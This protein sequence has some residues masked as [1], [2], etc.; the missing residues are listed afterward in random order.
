VQLEKSMERKTMQNNKDGIIHDFKKI[1]TK[2]GYRGGIQR[3]FKIG[4]LKTTGKLYRIKNIN[5]SARVSG[6]KERGV[7]DASEKIR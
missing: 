3:G 7:I 2:E 6:L 4:N 5:D 1:D